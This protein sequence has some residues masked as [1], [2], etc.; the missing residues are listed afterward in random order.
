MNKTHISRRNFLKGVG[1]SAGFALISSYSVEAKQSTQTTRDFRLAIE[2]NMQFDTAK[3]IKIWSPIAMP[4]SFQTPYNLKIT[5]NY[6]N[7]FFVD[8][9]QTPLIQATWENDMLEKHLKVS[10]DIKTYHTKNN[11]VMKNFEYH[12][13]K[14]RYIRT[15][16]K[17]ADITSSLISNNDTQLRKVY[18]IFAWIAT[19]IPYEEAMN[20]KG[21]RSIKQNNGEVIMR[22][23]DISATSIFVAMCRCAGIQAA[24]AFGL[25]L[26]SNRYENQKKIIRPEPYTRAIAKINNKWIPSDILLAI[27]LIKESPS[28]INHAIDVAFN[29]W[30]N[31]W[32]LLN[33]ARDVSLEDSRILLSTIQEAYGEIDGTKLSSYDSSHFATQILA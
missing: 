21:I 30:D 23:E 6:N 8:S 7:Y 9:N 18:K 31:N 24:E 14:D 2:Y 26:D 15:D 22:G 4:H 11:I 19:N 27:S 12:S 28:K 10:F 33:F 13:T 29:E 25:K 5:G 1:A 20:T 32:I 17:I 16:G 3:T